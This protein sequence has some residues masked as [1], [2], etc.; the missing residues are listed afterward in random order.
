[1]TESRGKPAT[2]EQNDALNALIV[3]RF[4]YT[5]SFHSGGKPVVGSRAVEVVVDLVDESRSSLLAIVEED[6]GE[7]RASRLPG[8][9]VGQSRSSQWR[10]RF[11]EKDSRLRRKVAKVG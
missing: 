4:S 2:V 1:M 10:V 8:S 5:H 6:L 11:G 3:L 7:K 9:R